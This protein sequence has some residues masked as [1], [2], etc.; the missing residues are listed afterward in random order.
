MPRFILAILI[1][2]LF[3]AQPVLANSLFSDKTLA[4]H[5]AF[6]EQL[7][8]SHCSLSESSPSLSNNTI[9]KVAEALAQAEKMDKDIKLEKGLLEQMQKMLPRFIDCDRVDAS[10]LEDVM[11]GILAFLGVNRQ[12]PSVERRTYIQYAMKLSEIENK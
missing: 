3:L 2:L 10:P 4:S 5:K 11:D 9:N 7:V 6:Y 1:P 8:V 12:I